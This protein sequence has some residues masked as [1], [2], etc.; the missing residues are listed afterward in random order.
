MSTI[1]PLPSQS[2]VAP[3]PKRRRVWWLALGTLLLASFTVASRPYRESLGIRASNDILEKDVKALREETRQYKR[4]ISALDTA[5]GR[6]LLGRRTGLVAEREQ[7]LN[8]PD[9]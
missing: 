1:Q 7:R 9:K 6:V 5:E 4:E 8:I 2:L 3:K